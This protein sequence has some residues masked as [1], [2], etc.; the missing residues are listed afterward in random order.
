[1]PRSSEIPNN[2]SNLPP[3]WKNMSVNEREKWA[4]RNRFQRQEEGNAFLEAAKLAPIYGQILRRAN[5]SAEDVKKTLDK[6][7]T[8]PIPKG[9]ETIK[10][11]R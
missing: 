1:M 8:D 7:V 9:I 4:D 2:N 5:V 10:K 11:A 3:E 6:F